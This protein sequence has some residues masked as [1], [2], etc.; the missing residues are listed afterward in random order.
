MA[1]TQS[2]NDFDRAPGITPGARRVRNLTLWAVCALAWF[3]L[4]RVTKLYADGF[5]VGEAVAPDVAGLVGFSLV[6]N[7]GV[8]WGAFSGAVGAI[9]LFTALLCLVIA[10]FA[11]YW[12]REAGRL[13]MFALGIL[14]AGGVGNLLDRVALGYVVDFIEPLFID[15]PTFNVADIGV[16]C[17]IV[18]LMAS[19]IAQMVREG[20]G[21]DVRNGAE[22][23]KDRIDKE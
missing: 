5:H 13:D 15:F 14:F 20:A 7:F 21:K 11:V 17:G 22:T 1:D 12:S 23:N 8:A 2:H 18:L 19:L 10:A 3:A 9:S 4:D 16:T 6:H